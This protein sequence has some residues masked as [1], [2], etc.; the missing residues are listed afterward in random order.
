MLS[1]FG[2]IYWL[3]GCSSIDEFELVIIFWGYWNTVIKDY[4]LCSYTNTLVNRRYLLVLVARNLQKKVY[5]L[6]LSE[7][8]YPKKRVSDI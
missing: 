3:I 5:F 2:Y 4:F 6:F 7:K 1:D 8:H